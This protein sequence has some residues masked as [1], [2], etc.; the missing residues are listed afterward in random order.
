MKVIQNN[1]KPNETNVSEKITCPS[2]TSVIEYTNA[3][4]THTFWR[5]EGWTNSNIKYKGFICPSC[6]YE[7]GI[8]TLYGS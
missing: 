3:D 6:N 4:L 7:L 5:T 1:H 2:C 8:E